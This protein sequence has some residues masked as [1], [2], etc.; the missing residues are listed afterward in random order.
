MQSS[1]ITSFWYQN[2]KLGFGIVKIAFQPWKNLKESVCGY[3][4][5]IDEWNTTKLS[6]KELN[7]PESRTKKQDWLHKMTWVRTTKP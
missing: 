7:V 1:S 3:N 2:L 5:P 4:V 6:R